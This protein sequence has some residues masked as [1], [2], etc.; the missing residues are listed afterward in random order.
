MESLAR[1]HVFHDGNKRT[2][3]IATRIFLLINNHIIWYPLHTAAFITYIA[4]SKESPEMLVNEIKTFL[5]EWSIDLSDMT[6]AKNKLESWSRQVFISNILRRYKPEMYV[7][8][9]KEWLAFENEA[10]IGDFVTRST[11]YLLNMDI[12]I[13]TI[14]DMISNETNEFY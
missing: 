3:L 6:T 12:S 11:K 2:A 13:R 1:L 14:R 5:D 7:N 9:I 4:N 8:G 10:D